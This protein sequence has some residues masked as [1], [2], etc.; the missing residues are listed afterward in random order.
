MR[1]EEAKSEVWPAALTQK[2]RWD[3]V[4]RSKERGVAG[5]VG[6]IPTKRTY[7]PAKHDVSQRSMAVKIMDG[8]MG[9]NFS[10]PLMWEPVPMRHQ[11]KSVKPLLPGCW[12]QP[13]KALCI[14]NNSSLTHPRGGSRTASTIWPSFPRTSARHELNYPW[15]KTELSTCCWRWQDTTYR[16]PRP[17]AR[18]RARYPL[19]VRSH[20]HARNPRIAHTCENARKIT[21]RSRLTIWISRPLP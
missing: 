9:I 1:C 7:Q 17:H 10:N 13:S 19:R 3:E 5:R 18:L 16:N 15:L 11:Y 4:R 20:T 8:L 2:R 6:P 21:C 14:W 12:V